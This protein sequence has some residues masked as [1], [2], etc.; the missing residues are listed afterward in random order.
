MDKATVSD[1]NTHWGIA[2]SHPLVDVPEGS[3]VAGHDE[4]SGFPAIKTHI[5]AEC[6]IFRQAVSEDTHVISGILRAAAKRMMAQG[7]KQWDEKYPT[8]THVASDIKRGEGHILTS[9]GKIIA[10][11]AVVTDGE[12][13]YENISGKWLSDRQYVVVHR[14]AVS[15]EHECKGVGRTF[16]EHVEQYARSRGIYSFRV[17]TNFD[18]FAMLRLLEKL[19][20]TYCGEISYNGSPRKA[21]EKLL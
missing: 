18:N 19:G 10:Y 2:D 5:T 1:Y 9:E 20:F 8:E 13:A 14:M 21:F 12:P 15:M 17:D 7:K 16:L 3:Q 6:P 4:H 11:G